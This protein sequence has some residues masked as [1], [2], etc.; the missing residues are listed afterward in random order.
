MT[1]TFNSYRNCHLSHQANLQAVKLERQYKDT[2]LISPVR[3]VSHLT[4]FTQSSL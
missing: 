3:L 4:R 2:L 1:K